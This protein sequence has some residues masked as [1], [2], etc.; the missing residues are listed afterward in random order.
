MELDINFCHFWT[1]VSW[2]MGL[3][4]G[5]VVK[6]S[7][8]QY[9]R[10]KRCGFNTWVPVPLFFTGKFHGQRRLMGYR[11]WG[12]RV[13]HN[14]AHEES[15]MV[16]I[17]NP[18]TTHAFSS[19]PFIYPWHIFTNTCVHPTQLGGYRFVNIG[20]YHSLSLQ[21]KSPEPSLFIISLKTIA[22]NMRLNFF[23]WEFS[24]MLDLLYHQ[25]MIPNVCFIGKFTETFLV[26]K[27]KNKIFNWC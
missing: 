20:K 21:P 13:R 22:L 24:F 18:R 26:A 5:T 8:C 14:W 9:R 11:S 27:Y 10:Y 17:P 15:L 2:S 1:S 19:L 16:N 4:G 25:I 23:L 6:E 7:S 12:C 3:P